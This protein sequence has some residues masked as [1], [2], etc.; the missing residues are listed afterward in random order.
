M[1]HHLSHGSLRH[2]THPTS[3]KHFAPVVLWPPTTVSVPGWPVT[4]AT[5]VTCAQVSA[6]A[7][8]STIVLRTE[9][10]QENGEVL[11]HCEEMKAE[12]V[13]SDAPYRVPSRTACV[14]S[15]CRL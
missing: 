10:C 1:E 4:N 11:L 5:H 13:E 15:S 2:Q 6:P 3:E 12:E 8:R 9:P 14:R 7:L